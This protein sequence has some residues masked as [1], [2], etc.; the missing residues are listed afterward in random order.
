MR[1]RLH[2]RL[3]HDEHH[4]G[5]LEVACQAYRLLPVAFDGQPDQARIHAAHVKQEQGGEGLAGRGGV[6]A[7]GDGG[8][9]EGRRRQRWPPADGAESCR[10]NRVPSTGRASTTPGSAT[11]ES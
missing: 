8:T 5:A 9:G 1:D 4:P 6:A 2:H 7:H 10:K 3:H 11:R